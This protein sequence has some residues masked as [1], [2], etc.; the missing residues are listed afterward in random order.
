MGE[1]AIGQGVSRFEDPRLIQG[2]G[3]YTDDV[4]L[5]GMAHGV[6]LRSPHA[7]AKIKSIN[8]DAAKAAPGVLAV[9]TSADV[10]AHGY[11]DLP[12]PGGLQAA[13]RP[14][15]VQAEISDPGRR[16]RALGRRRR[17]LCG[18]RDRGAGARRRRNDR[19]RFRAAAV[20]DL[21]RRSGQARRAESLGRCPRQHQL[22]RP[23]RQQ[24][25]DRRGLRQGRACRQSTIR[26]QPR[27]RRHHGAAR[28]G[29]G[30]SQRRRPLH[31]LHRDPAPAPDPRRTRQ[32]AR[33]AG[34]QGAHRHRRYRR[35]LRHEVADFQRNADGA[36]GLQDHRPAG[37]MDLDALGELH[38]RRAGAR[39]RHRQPN[40]RST[41]T[42]TSSACASRPSPPSAPICRPRM[43]AF[44]LNAGTLAGCLSHAGDG[45]RHHRGVLQHQ[46][47]PPLSRQRPPGSGLRHRA[48]G[49]SR[50]RRT[51]HRSGRT[52]APELHSAVGRCRSRPD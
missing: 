50:R 29:R 33:R 40:S 28:R 10:K 1:F 49:R 20:G 9:L 46:S 4:H 34:K 30:L 32:S 42:A 51:G 6:V 25:R 26:H 44:F 31:H 36:A 45:C 47:D 7:H 27:H 14:A 16:R 37:E 24:G 41:R 39:Q 22:R 52:A 17:R 21:D 2:G 43:P 5:P 35:L 48:H 12:V 19:G 38:Q 8:T 23:I 3:S 18:R 11:G 15:D 13:R